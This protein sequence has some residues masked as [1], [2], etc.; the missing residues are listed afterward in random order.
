[1]SN[2]NMSLV[3]DEVR[4]VFLGVIRRFNQRL[5]AVTA[6]HGARLVDVNAVTTAED[7]GARR[8][9]YIDTNHIRPSALIEAFE[10]FA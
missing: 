8:G 5:R 9:H 6:E 2:I 3:D 10:P 4:D 1:M 7:G